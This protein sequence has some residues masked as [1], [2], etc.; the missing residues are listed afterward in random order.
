MTSLFSKCLAFLMLTFLTGG[1]GA[2]EINVTFNSATDIPVTASGYIATGNTVNLTLNFAP[3][4]GTQLMVVKNTALDFIK[5][6][7]SNLAQGQEVT[8]SFGGVPYHFVANYYGGSGKDLVLQWAWTQVW[9][10][11][12]NDDGQ[13]DN[14]VDGSRNVPALLS[15]TALV[16]KTVT[17]VAAGAAHS[18][19][20]C[21]DGTVVA[22]GF[23]WDGQLGF[24]DFSNF[25]AGLVTVKGTALAGK[26]VIA[27]AAG[28]NH[29]L[30]LCSDGSLV[31]WGNNEAGQLGNN[32]ARNSHVPVA[33]SVSG[34]A[35]EGKT[36]VGLAAGY[37]HSLALCSDGTMVAW[38]FNSE[39]QLGNDT[40]TPSRVPVAVS[41]IGTPLAGKAV[42]SIAAGAMHNLAAC[43]D[44]SVVA[45][46]AHDG[47]ALG[48]GDVHDRHVPVAV[49]TLGTPLAGR[50]VIA[51]SGGFFHSLALCSDGTL[52]AWGD[53]FR[54]QLGSETGFPYLSAVPV[55]VKRIGTALNDKAVSSISAGASHSLALCMDGTVAAWGGNG[56]GQLGTGSANY[57]SQSA[58]AIITSSL[59]AGA[60]IVAAASGPTASH[61]LCI[62]AVS[63]AP[64]ITL[65]KSAAVLNKSTG[66]FEWLVQVKNT[67]PW[68]IPGFDLFIGGLPKNVSVW[69]GFPV[70]GDSPVYRVHH[71]VPVG[72]GQSV[73]VVVEFFSKNR[74]MPNLNPTMTTSLV[75]SDAPPGKG[76]YGIPV[77][78][79]VKVAGRGNLVQFRSVAGSSYRIWY[80]VPAAMSA[81]LP[82][83]AAAKDSSLGWLA[84]PVPV[85]GHSSATNWMDEGPPKTVFSPL[86]DSARQYRVEL[87][88]V[89]PR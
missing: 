22:W 16:G 85:V 65:P 67:S 8:L 54:G 75:P 82:G 61:S 71:G 34:T 32:S 12:N 20:L 7:F 66:L 87:L 86:D 74:Q 60:R 52:A 37:L 70:A 53:N 6:T 46:G 17:A 9:G 58:E 62:V 24:A 38:G 79:V 40:T 43:S 41:V 84:S 80:S 49:I 27:I 15:P 35:L 73:T 13:V 26:S 89:M 44:G 25:G 28:G 81:S 51:V 1:L 57:S 23:N 76:L 64:T 42:T 30:A 4:T 39:G 45:W 2:A 88:P 48:N 83:V 11:G 19:A 59:R 78:K 33:V 55:S 36:V 10:W 14:G 77:S 72:A 21:S 31:A 68:A 56:D 69:N 47:G 29:S 50:L 3:E 5:G 63:Q 18:L